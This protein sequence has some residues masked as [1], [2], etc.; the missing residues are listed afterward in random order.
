MDLVFHSRLW[1][2]IFMLVCHLA[3][4][5]LYK[6][7]LPSLHMHAWTLHIS[8]NFLSCW[9]SALAY[10]EGGHCAMATPLRP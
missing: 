8:L 10:G 5:L 9:L 1:I 3:H 2:L 4:H 7:F 6:F